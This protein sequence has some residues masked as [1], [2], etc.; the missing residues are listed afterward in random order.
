[1]TE[2]PRLYMQV[3]AALREQITDG[4]IKPGNPVPSIKTIC[5]E[6]GV[7]RHTAGKAIRLL[8]KDGLVTRVAGLGYYVL[9]VRHQGTVRRNEPPVEGWHI[10][11]P[12]M[13][14]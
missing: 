5:R 4:Q 9:G 6:A 2:D 8:E 1:M 3:A 13:K 12:P 11:E 7:S 14:S 10:P